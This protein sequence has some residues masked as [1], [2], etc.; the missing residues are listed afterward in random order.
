MSITGYKT[1]I[2][3]VL[4]MLGGLATML[5]VTLPEGA[6]QTIATNVDVVVGAGIALYGAVI[7]VLRAFT[8]SPMFSKF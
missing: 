4:S 8:N 5:G 1:A 2:V 7:L 3:G 6:V